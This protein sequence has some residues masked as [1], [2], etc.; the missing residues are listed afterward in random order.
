M[1]ISR[2]MADFTLG[3]ADLLRRIMGKKK[4][5]LLPPEREKFI[6]GA[7]AKGVDEKVANAVFDK[8]AKFAEYG[9]NKAHAAA[10]AFIAYQTAY[11]KAHY[12]VE[13]MAATMT[14]DKINTDKLAFFKNDLQQNGFKVLPPHINKSGVDFTVE[15][16]C[17]RYA[18][19]AV[20]NVGEAGMQAVVAERDKNG[21][22]KSIE[23][24]LQRVDV[25]AL[26]KRYVEN[27][28]KSGAFECLEPNR[29]YLFNNV[30]KMV[31]YAA[32]QTAAKKSAQMGLFGADASANK[33]KLKKCPEWPQ[34]E[35]LEYEKE[36]L[37]FYLS[38][39]PLD[40]F[41]TVLERMRVVDFT[42]IPAMV[43]T[44]GV[45]RGQLAGIVS[46]VRER[47]SQKGNRFAF[48]AASDKSASYEA[49]CFSDVLEASRDKLNSN[50]PLLFAVQAEK[51]EGEE[52]ISLRI[53]GVE[54][55]SEMMSKT[56]STLILKIESKECLPAIKKV[57]DAD[58][59][60]KSRVFIILTTPE[61]EV[62]IALPKHYML[63]P[64]T[65]SELSKIA[66]ILEIKQI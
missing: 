10:Y 36:A 55:L 62:E 54:L 35:K 4:A 28:A 14:L 6:K 12:P 25:S 1:Q 34:M 41:Q 15:D 47:I 59:D 24:F 7:K 46:E 2:V 32:D 57:L 49:I 11:L 3:G 38:A 27:L 13:F 58:G 26:N 52:Q 56:A 63:H 45:F 21:P 65:M 20:K 43:K 50:Q 23:D 48:I 22:F 9:F 61:N 33:L 64:K 40:S 60:G 16:N 39:H 19:S 44:T 18:L 31:A 51:R 8:M 29:A 5:E 53:I 42:D 37:G 30:E 17:V 66:G